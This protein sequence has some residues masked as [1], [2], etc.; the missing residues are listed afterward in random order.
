MECAL[1][2]RWLYYVTPEQVEIRIEKRDVFNGLR[3]DHI[4]TRTKIQR[5]FTRTGS[6][7]KQLDTLA[8][9]KIPEMIEDV[10]SACRDIEKCIINGAAPTQC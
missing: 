2:K 6:V 10:N 8:R 5:R 1:R 4:W 7:T 3:Q 9:N